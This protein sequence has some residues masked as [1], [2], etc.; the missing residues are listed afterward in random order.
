MW[1]G[2]WAD[3]FSTTVVMLSICLSVTKQG[4]CSAD[5]TIDGVLTC[6]LIHVAWNVGRPIQHNRSDA[7]NLPL[8]H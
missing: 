5:H 7:L 3:R 8:G 1:R 4:R 6:I 2:T